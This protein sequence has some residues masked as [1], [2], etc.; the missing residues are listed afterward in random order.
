MENDLETKKR[1]GN[2]QSKLY[3][4]KNKE[5]HNKKRKNY[6]RQAWEDRKDKETDKTRRQTPEYKAKEKTRR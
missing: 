5:E 1:I 2:L 6:K 3:Y 4:I